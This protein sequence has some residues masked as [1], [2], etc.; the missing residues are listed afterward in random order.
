MFTPSEIA[1]LRNAVE[2]LREKTRNI[3]DDPNYVR[4]FQLR[5]ERRISEYTQLLAKL[6]SPA[7]YTRGELS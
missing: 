7:M 5:A 4:T 3:A 1:I 6:K 2:Q